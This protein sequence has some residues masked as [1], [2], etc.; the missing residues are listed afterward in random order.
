M[1][2]GAEERRTPV[3]GRKEVVGGCIHRA[4][5]EGRWEVEAEVEAL[6]ESSVALPRVCACRTRAKP[7]RRAFCF[8]KVNICRKKEGGKK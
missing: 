2:S 1:P 5:K 3:E 4:G 8:V 6:E 7:C